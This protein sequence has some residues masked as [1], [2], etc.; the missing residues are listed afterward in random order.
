MQVVCLSVKISDIS[1]H[2]CQ[3]KKIE[4]FGRSWMHKQDINLIMHMHIYHTRLS[5]QEFET[6]NKP[7]TT[8][9][10]NNQVSY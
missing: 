9:A 6:I 10:E 7:T 8:R 3:G 2:L 5:T 4:Q 1:A